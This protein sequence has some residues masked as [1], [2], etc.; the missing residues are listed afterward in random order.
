MCETHSPSSGE[1]IKC[2]HLIWKCVYFEARDGSSKSA[3]YFFFLIA[4][5]KMSSASRQRHLQRRTQARKKWDL[6]VDMDSRMINLTC[7][8]LN[9][10]HQAAVFSPFDIPLPLLFC[11]FCFVR[12]V[13]TTVI[14]YS[15]KALVLSRPDEQKIWSCAHTSTNPVTI[16]TR[17]LFIWFYKNSLQDWTE[18]S[19]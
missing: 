13:G 8:T 16:W 6:N 14:I 12:K 3:H 15:P 7:K 4:G 19:I 1:L 10:D 9:F 17:I 2:N 5:S 11:F 18:C